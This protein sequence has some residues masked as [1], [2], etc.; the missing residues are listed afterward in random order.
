MKSFFFKIFHQE[1]LHLEAIINDEKLNEEELLTLVSSLLMARKLLNE[2]IPASNSGQGWRILNRT[3][4]LLLKKK[5]LNKE[6]QLHK[7]L[8]NE[9]F[10]RHPLICLAEVEIINELNM[11]SSDLGKLLQ[12][13]KAPMVLFKIRSFLES[14]NNSQDLEILPGFAAQLMLKWLYP[15]HLTL[16][17]QAQQPNLATQKQLFCALL[18]L[19]VFSRLLGSFNNP[20]WKMTSLESTALREALELLLAA[21]YYFERI[22]LPARKAAQKLNHF[23][24][25]E[26][27]LNEADAEFWADWHENYH[28]TAPEIFQKMRTIYDAYCNDWLQLWNKAENDKLW[29]RFYNQTLE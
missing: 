24:S 28:M 22:R 29:R 6:Q 17:D 8:L 7:Q 12:K 3:Q 5:S 14:L 2:L 15:I 23:I 9:G 26:K 13:L 1:T 21:E 11:V 10:S 27:I 25:L 16:A 19:N 18:E 20:L 4:R